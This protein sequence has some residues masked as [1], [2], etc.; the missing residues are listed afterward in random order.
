MAGP[1]REPGLPGHWAAKTG[2]GR[3]ALWLGGDVQSCKQTAPSLPKEARVLGAV[4]FY[5]S[6]LFKTIS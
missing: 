5:T 2:L 4:Y 1:G 3:W 6:N